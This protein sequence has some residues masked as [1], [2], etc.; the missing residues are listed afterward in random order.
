MNSQNPIN[1]NFKCVDLEEKSVITDKKCEYIQCVHIYVTLRDN[2]N[3]SFSFFT[4]NFSKEPFMPQ[5]LLGPPG[6]VGHKSENFRQGSFSGRVKGIASRV[7]T[8]SAI[9]FML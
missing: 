7:P 6:K 4:S 5:V 1:C 3:N 9:I 2:K 8:N